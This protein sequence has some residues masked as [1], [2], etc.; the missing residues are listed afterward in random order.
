MVQHD[1]SCFI[2]LVLILLS[3]VCLK[4]VVALVFAYCWI[5]SFGLL[6][7]KF[8]CASTKNKLNFTL[9]LDGS[10]PTVGLYPSR[11]ENLFILAI[12]L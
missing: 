10:R 7:T 11:T 8:V 4:I 3:E 12:I 9:Q 5:V 2:R 1:L 6:A